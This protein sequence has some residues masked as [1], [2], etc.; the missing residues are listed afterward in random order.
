MLLTFLMSL[1]LYHLNEL[2]S[3]NFEIIT[4]RCRVCIVCIE[5]VDIYCWRNRNMMSFF[6]AF[7]A[8]LKLRCFVKKMF[9]H[10]IDWFSNVSREV[11]IFNLS[12]AGQTYFVNGFHSDSNKCI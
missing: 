9:D 10:V 4:E 12:L 1:L 3:S 2:L 11:T 6:T 8:I 5:G 7:Q